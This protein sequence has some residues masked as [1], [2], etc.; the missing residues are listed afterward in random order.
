[1]KG[2]ATPSTTRGETISSYAYIYIYIYIWF[3]SSN[4][5][6]HSRLM[7]YH[8]RPRRVEIQIAGDKVLYVIK[9]KNCNEYARN[10]TSPL[11]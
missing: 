11:I 6:E 5:I 2:N 7:E 9:K 10:G 8:T 4:R 1:M 3:S